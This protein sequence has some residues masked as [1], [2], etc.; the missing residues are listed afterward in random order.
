MIRAVGGEEAW[1]LA[2]LHAVTVAH[3]Y[4]H[5]FP[6]ESAAPTAAELIDL[7]QASL[8]EPNTEAWAWEVDGVIVGSVVLSAAP[9]TPSG[10]TLSRLH[11]HPDH[12]GQGIGGRLHDHVLAAAA[13][14]G[15]SAINLWVLEAN[16]RARTIYERRGWTYV[17]GPVV[18]NDPPEIVDVLYERPLP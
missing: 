2:E 13:E 8:A 1:T 16:E 17:P 4:A 6:P 3:G 10:L 14:R 12:Q 5:I 18:R 7:W 15:A 9:S 11:V